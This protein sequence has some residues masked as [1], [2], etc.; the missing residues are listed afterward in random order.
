MVTHYFRVQIPM[1]AGVLLNSQN[2]TFLDGVTPLETAEGHKGSWS[3]INDSI[4]QLLNSLRKE[5]AT[6]G[7]NYILNLLTTFNWSATQ[8]FQSREW[9]YNPLQEVIKPFS[10][11]TRFLMT[12][13]YMSKKKKMSEIEVFKKTLRY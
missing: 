12:Q 11:G 6:M 9:V 5:A 4:Q 3:L 2:K 13:M 10:I 8:F 7:Y 1:L